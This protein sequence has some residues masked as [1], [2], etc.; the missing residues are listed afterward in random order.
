VTGRTLSRRAVLRWAGGLGLMTVV[1]AGGFVG[2][3]YANAGSG[4]VGTLS[5]RN[6]LRIPPLLTPQGADGRRRFRLRAQRGRAEL[7]PGTSTPAW[8]YNGAYLGPT[9]RARR[10]DR[11]VIDLTNEVGETTTTHWHGMRLPA[12]MDGGPH[13]PIASGET[14]SPTWT[15]DQPAA[16]LWYHPHLHHSTAEHVY[17]GLAGLFIIDDDAAESLAL[18]SEYGVDDIPVVVQDRKFHGDGSLDSR[19]LNYGGLSIT[20]LLG[21]TILVNGTYDPHVEVTRTLTRFRLLNA[22]NARVYDIGFADNRTFSI[23]ASDSGLLPAP[24]PATRVLLSPGERAE[25]VVSFGPG[26]RV[27]L[28]SHPPALGANLLYERLAGGTDTLDLLEVRASRRLAPS[29]P[30]PSRLVDPAPIAL[31]ESATTREFVMGDF[32][33]NGRTMD[34]G[35]IDHVVPAGVTEAWTVTNAGGF[36]SNGLPHS[37]HVH[38]ANFVVL[39][40][41]G[42]RP[43]AHARGAKDTVFVPPRTTVRLAVQFGPYSDP[44]H[45]YMYHC[46]ILAH[47]DA[48]MMGQFL[49]V[50]PEDRPRIKVTAVRDTRAHHQEH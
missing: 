17:Q 50:S 27:V 13:Q 35:R 8:G 14:W 31:P 47:E 45:P 42:K 29:P 40:V 12:V 21:G 10:G 6:R 5:F 3:L 11:V 2:W 36:P 1:P 48:G 7:L 43:R 18:P 24:Q 38:E 34:H 44:E 4:N 32:T 39:D 20:G 22:S 23:I 9:L 15:I 19:G 46:H 25:I 41:N 30:L 16:T 37:F 33:L 26:E 28:R 49:L